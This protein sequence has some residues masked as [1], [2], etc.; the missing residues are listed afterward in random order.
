[1]LLELNSAYP[2]QDNT[3]DKALKRSSQVPMDYLDMGSDL[4]LE[5]RGRQV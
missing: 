5:Q 4:D 3:P 2:F 1:M